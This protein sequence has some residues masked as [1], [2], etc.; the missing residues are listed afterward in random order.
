MASSGSSDVREDFH[1][2]QTLPLGIVIT[3]KEMEVVF[4]NQKMERWTE[5]SA[6]EIVGDSLV[7]RFPSVGAKKYQGRIKQVIQGGPAVIFSSQLHPHFIPAKLPNGD[8]RTQHTTVTR[9]PMKGDREDLLM[10]S[11]QDVTETVRHL[12]RIKRLRK[13]ALDQIEE[14]KKAE[15]ALRESEERFRLLFKNLPLG[16]FQYSNDAHIQTVNEAFIQIL[17]STREQLE[18]MNLYD[19]P[20]KQIVA[21]IQK[22]LDGEKAHY[23][24]EYVSVTSGK[25]T[26][27]KAEFAPIRLTSGE[28]LGGVGIVEDISERLS[29][30]RE[31]EERETQYRLMVEASEE[32]FF[33]IHDRDHCFTYL[34]PS[35]KNVLGYERDELMGKP[36]DVLLVGD[37]R[38]DEVHKY[39]HHALETGEK[40]D[41][42]TAAVNHKDGHEIYLELVESP[43]SKEKDVEGI[44]GFARDIT[45]RVLAQRELRENKEMLDSINRN[46]EEGIFRFRPGKGIVYAN[47]ALARIYG[48]DST[49]AFMNELENA[50]QSDHKMLGPLLEIIN[51]GHSLVNREIKLTRHDGTEFWGLVSLTRIDNAQ[52]EAMYYDGALTDITERKEVDM[53][54]AA[55]YR[56]ADKTSTMKEPQIFYRDIHR[57]VSELMVAR[58]FYIAECDTEKQLIWFPYDVDRYDKVDSKK[59][60]GNGL[61]EY[62][63]RTGEPTLL[64]EQ[65]IRKMVEAGEVE[66]IGE[67]AK[68]WMG[69]PIRSINETYG[70][71]V[72][73]SY[74]DEAIYTTRDLDILTFVSQHLATALERSRYEEDLLKAKEEAEEASQSK[75]IFLANM[76]HELRT[77]LNSIIGYTRRVLKRT[78]DQIDNQSETALNT[79]QRNAQNLLTL[80]NDLLDFSKIEAGKMTYQMQRMELTSIVQETLDELEPL[81][82]SK[83]LDL[84]FNSQENHYIYADPNRLKQVLVN[85]ISNGIKFTDNGYVS[86]EIEQK[87]ERGKKVEYIHVIDTGIGIPDEK[88]QHIFNVFEQAHSPDLGKGGT[89]LGLSIAQKIITDMNGQMKVD[90]T[91]DEG[92]TFTVVLPGAELNN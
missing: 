59:A 62:V 20:S 78:N 82:S 91:Y 81:A 76:S 38:D 7:E 47:K 27:V 31:L 69:V 92:S 72:V 5:I 23:E 12:N 6:S 29:T 4:W 52:G 80:I 3:N 1:Y 57:I 43:V 36:Y 77:P 40:S 54:Q 65:D 22:S 63:I 30:L 71:L 51:N 11:I 17:G 61:T 55:L 42:Y 75:S 89:G 66:L 33:Y 48:F 85:L 9:V 35:V 26:H 32:V 10:F 41:I 67:M 64:F 70:A 15:R 84:K 18:N 24:G 50:V 87:H 21:C 83:D 45:D 86:V 60:F 68:A 74:T 8:L 19:L 16:I 73:Q 44:Q 58:N 2:L 37:N 79:V 53:V 90:S 34:S 14:R 49:A 28:I 88:L 39:T 25:S 56:I 13:E 46:I